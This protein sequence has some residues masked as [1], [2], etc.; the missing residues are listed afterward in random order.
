MPLVRQ[1]RLSVLVFRGTLG[2]T[3]EAGE[4]SSSL[5][6]GKGMQEILE[7]ELD[8]MDVAVAHLS[9][10]SAFQERQVVLIDVSQGQ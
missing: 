1:A 5:R 2:T 8:H 3:D 4:K 10:E 9:A 6:S 7:D